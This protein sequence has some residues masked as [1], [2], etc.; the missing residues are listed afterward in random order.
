M[1]KVL[2]VILFMCFMS[3][4]FAEY[5]NEYPLQQTQNNKE[6]KIYSQSGSL[7]GYIKPTG[8]NQYKTYNKYHQYSG[9]YKQTGNKIKKY[10]R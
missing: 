2:C 10:N 3:P 7:Q 1:K 6:V 5:K 9:R 8:N 4:A